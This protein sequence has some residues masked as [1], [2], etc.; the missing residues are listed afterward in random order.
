M[1]FNG[2]ES[3]LWNNIRDAFSD[4]IKTMYQNLRSGT[5]FNYEYIRDKM[6]AHQTTWPEAIWNIDAYLKWLYPY[7]S[8]NENYLEMLQGDKKAQRDWWLYNGFRYRD[9]K[10]NCGD[11]TSNYIT[12]RLY[13]PGEIAITPYAHIWPRVKFGS[14]MMGERGK[15]NQTYYFS[16]P[17]GSNPNDLETYI[18]SADRIADIGDLSALQVGLANFGAAVKLQSI[19]LGSAAEDYVNQKLTSLTL[20]SNKLLRYLNVENCIALSTPID[21]SECSGLETVKAKGSSLTGFTFPNG[22]HLETVE[23]PSTLANLTIL[24]QKNIKTLELEGYEN[25]TTLQLENTPNIDLETIINNATNLDRVRLINM[26]WN[27]TSEE[28]L[29]TTITRLEA[30]AGMDATGTNTTN[31]VVTGKVYV[32]SI[33][34]AFLEEINDNFPE[35]IVVV[36]GVAK[37]FIRYLNYDNTLLY[38]YIAD[39]G[40]DAIDPVALGYIEEEP[41]RPD[42]ETAKYSYIGWKDLPK[43][44]TKPY[45][46]IAKYYSTYRVDFANENGTIILNSQW[47]DDGKAAVEPVAAGYIAEPTKTATDQYSYKFTGWDLPFDNITAPLVL[48]PVFTETLRDY[49]VY[50][51]NDQ[52]RLQEG[53]VYYGEYASYLGDTTQ[54]YKMINGVASEYYDFTGWSPSLDAPIT[55]PTYF[56]AQ[57]SFD[58]YIEEDWATIAENVKNGNVDKYSLAGR[59]VFTYAVDGN[60]SVVEAEIVGINHDQLSTLDNTYN[61]GAAVAGLSFIIRLLG[62]D[63]RIVNGNSQTDSAGNTSLNAG[64]WEKCD[65]RTWCNNDLLAALPEDLQAV[66]KEVVKISDTGYYTKSLITTVDKIWLPSDRELNGEDTNYV[67]AGQG[68]PYP[69]FTNNTSRVKANPETGKLIYWTRSTGIDGQHFFRY[70]DA[71]GN[72]N[73]NGGGNYGGIA[74]GFCI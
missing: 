72:M 45:N 15:R 51:Y 21:A 23:L 74:F 46:I 5:K 12:L 43:G 65:L 32:D 42:T 58:G 11:A 4:D 53:R 16:N 20:G 28:T 3:V 19:I 22:G 44:I 17:E 62:N 57:F 64:G 71:Q 63:Y 34:N 25:L 24:N 29:R 26:T 37:F 49:P 60:T 10:Y 56:Y 55:G 13:A 1:V 2:Q 59:K 69:M 40:T 27:A 48:Y 9:S 68:E 54:I 35:L 18:Y 36:G 73:S 14:V 6:A 31:A 39:E 38:R 61:G 33:T 70:A 41:T 8:L 50:F 52:T 30:C 67:V 47:I 66:I 7:L